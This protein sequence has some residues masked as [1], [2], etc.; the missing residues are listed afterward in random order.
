MKLLVSSSEARSRPKNLPRFVKPSGRRGVKRD[1]L[2][3]T[4]LSDLVDMG[5]DKIKG[6]VGQGGKRK[7]T[8]SSEI[9]GAKTQKLDN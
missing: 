5:C 9:P 7:F 6:I 3:Q 4:Q 8:G 2:V 1:E